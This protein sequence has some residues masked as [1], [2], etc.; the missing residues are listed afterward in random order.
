MRVFVTGATGFVGSA[1]VR[2]LL[3]AG[4]SVLGLAR[5][6]A[7]A[8]ALAEA[9]AEALRGDLS[10]IKALQ[11][12][13]E[14]ADAVAHLAFIHD[15]SKFAENSAIDKAAI[16]AIGEVLIGT[17]KP[18][19]VTSGVAVLPQGR[20]VTELEVAQHHFPRKSEETA[21]ELAERGVKASAVR[22]PPTTHGAGDHG[23]VPGLIDI[24]RA[25]GVAAYVGDGTNHWPATHR[26]DA[27]VVYRLALEKPTAGVR[28]HAI[29]EEG[30]EF[31]AI[32]EVIGR[33][34][35]VPVVSK[36]PEEAMEHFGFLGMFVGADVRASSAWTR[37]TLGWAPKQPGLLADLDTEEYF[38]GSSKYSRP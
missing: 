4:H 9:G 23:F 12:G 36:T 7:N 3:G 20:V 6:D 28:Y 5:N 1:V 27:A 34:L 8:A 33:R 14:Q 37:E 25:K 29:A 35:G 31:R 24:A 13:A 26:A 11:S 15:F 30:V 19:L 2:E 10:D 21:I 22:L 16:E 38:A 18:L 17:E 32:A